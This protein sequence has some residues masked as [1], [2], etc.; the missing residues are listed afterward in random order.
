MTKAGDPVRR[1][2]EAEIRDAGGGGHFVAIPFDVEEVFGGKR[3]RVRA[4]F[5]GS[6]D[7]PYRGS[8]V[9]MGQPHHILIVRKDIREAIGKGAGDTVRVEVWEDTEPREVTVP[10][11]FRDALD[12]EPRAR[13]TFDAMSYTHRR[14]YVQWIQD[15]RRSETRIRRIDKAIRMIRDG[16][17]R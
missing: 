11:D 17:V 15:A 1:S 12:A 14:E 3:V 10:A 13:S 4:T 5:D 16:Q 9:R 7:P 8:L 2:F 6:P